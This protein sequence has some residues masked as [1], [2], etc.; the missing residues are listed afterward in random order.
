MG[1]SIELNDTLQITFEQGFP[2]ELDYKKHKIKP[3]VAD[4]F[5]G[6][7]FEFKDKP[8]IRIYKLPPVRNFLVQNINGKWLYWGLVHV[9]EV[10]HDNIKQTTSGKFK[11]IYIYTPDEMKYAH[12]MIDRDKDTDYLDVM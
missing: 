8:N 5:E 1:S 3:F 10:I 11:I 2:K 9:V 4:N 7:V 6:R 12:K